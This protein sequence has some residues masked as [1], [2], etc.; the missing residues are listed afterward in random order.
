[1]AKN[2]SVQNA[3]DRDEYKNKSKNRQYRE[4][5]ILHKKTKKS[6]NNNFTDFSKINYFKCCQKNIMVVIAPFSNSLKNRKKNSL[7]LF[8]LHQFKL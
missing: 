5:E 8:R 1:M 2:N 4:N 3:I 7:M 6:E